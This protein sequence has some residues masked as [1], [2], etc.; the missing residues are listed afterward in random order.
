MRNYIYRANVSFMTLLLCLILTVPARAAD[1]VETAGNI[2]QLALPA[3]AAGLTLV[4]HDQ[5][6]FIQLVESGI[7][8]LG[9]TY[10]LKY[11]VSATRPNGGEHSFPSGHSSASFA[12]AEFIRERYG[13]NYGIPAYLAASF[14]GYSRVESK[15]HYTRDVIAGALIGIGSSW[16]FTT[17]DKEWNARPVAGNSFYGISLSRNW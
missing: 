1:A 8:T 4:N 14:V 5:K 15:E 2:I 17:P 16:L 3:G 6:G 9:I 12:S 7:L 13:W 11:T 10:G